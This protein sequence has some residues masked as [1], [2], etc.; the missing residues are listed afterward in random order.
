MVMRRGG[1]GRG[2]V[3]TTGSGQ[4]LYK[5]RSRDDKLM[6]WVKR[7][8]LKQVLRNQRRHREEIL[9][10]KQFEKQKGIIAAIVLSTALQDG[11]FEADQAR[12]E[13][14]LREYDLKSATNK[15]AAF[16]ELERKLWIPPRIRNSEGLSDGLIPLAP[17]FVDT[18]EVRAERRRLRLQAGAVPGR[19]AIYDAIHPPPP[20]AASMAERVRGSW[21]D[22][23][24]SDE[25]SAPDFDAA[26]Y[27]E[28]S[29]YAFPQGDAENPH[30][31]GAEW[32][33][34]AIEA[35]GLHVETQTTLDMEKDFVIDPHEDA[36]CVCVCVCVCVCGVHTHTRT[37][38][39]THT[40]HT[41]SLS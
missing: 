9:E 1:A 5:G 31:P 30:R 29:V 15:S 6:D 12:V 35:M 16:A 13:A 36:R 28:P 34:A 26:T 41:L 14:A 33:K 21:A 23:E 11:D 37:H 38:K 18:P 3:M 7:K 22:D 20:G 19:G 10:R 24:S 17:D 39:H 27:I 4:I 32:G 40:P 25:T 2:A 8:R